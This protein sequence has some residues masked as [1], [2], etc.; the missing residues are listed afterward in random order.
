ML[1]NQTSS[2]G[3]S[4]FPV[5]SF[6]TYFRAQNRRHLK[7]WKTLLIIFKILITVDLT[8]KKAVMKKKLQLSLKLISQN[9]SVTWR[10]ISQN[11][12]VT[13]IVVFRKK[14]TSTLTL[15]LM[16]QLT[17]QLTYF[18]SMISFDA[19][20]KHQKTS[21]FLMFSG[22]TKEISDMKCVN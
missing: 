20:W 5:I 2:R 4:T 6:P 17:W 11:W 19:P 9:Q 18:M 22:G 1:Y 13:L 8:A 7:K 21:G 16:N 14:K 12:S 10:L 15:I 3:F